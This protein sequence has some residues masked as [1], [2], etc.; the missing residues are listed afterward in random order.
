MKT[1]RTDFLIGFDVSP[2]L[3][4]KTVVAYYSLRLY[5]ALKELLGEEHLHTLQW[6]KTAEKILLIH[7]ELYETWRAAE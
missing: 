2:V 7:R 5:R 6:Q 3:G 4:R 1:A